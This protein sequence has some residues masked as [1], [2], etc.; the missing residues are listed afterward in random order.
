VGYGFDASFCG[1]GNHHNSQETK[2]NKTK[3]T[4]KNQT[5]PSQA[6]QPE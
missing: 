4:N 1:E 5:K 2:Q 6:N 3:Q